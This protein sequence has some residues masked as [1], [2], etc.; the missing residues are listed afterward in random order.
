MIKKLTLE[1]FKETLTEVE[2]FIQECSALSLTALNEKYFN[3]EENKSR[4]EKAYNALESVGIDLSS[5]ED[6]YSNAIGN[7]AYFSQQA[8]IGF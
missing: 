5:V 8:N 4:L 2:S 1:Q 3:I 7:L 6:R